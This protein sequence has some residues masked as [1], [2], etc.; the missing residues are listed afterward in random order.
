MVTARFVS[1]R[2]ASHLFLLLQ[3]Y[4]V[5]NNATIPIVG[6]PETV[7]NTYIEQLVAGA[8]AAIDFKGNVVSE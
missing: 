7:N 1:M 4:A 2:G 3:G 5:L 8:K 6:D